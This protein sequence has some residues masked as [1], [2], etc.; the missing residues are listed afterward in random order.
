MDRRVFPD[1]KYASVVYDR[2]SDLPEDGRQES[3]QPLSKPAVVAFLDLGTNSIRL[4]LV[5]VNPDLS[6]TVLTRQKEVVRLGE[7]EF[8]DQTLQP[9][10]MQRATQI[11]RQFADLARTRQAQEI[12]AIATSATRE[13]ANQAEFVQLIKDE[14]GLELHVVSGKEEARLIYLGVSSGLN[15]GRRKALF[16]DIGGG[17]T[18]TIVGDQ[19][20]YDF[21]ETHKLGAMRLASLFVLPGETGP[22][23]K[24]RY[25]LLKNYVRNAIVRTVQHLKDHPVEMVLGSSGSITNLAEVAYRYFHD[26][27]FDRDSTVTLEEISDTLQMLCRL[28]LDERREVPGINP[29]RADIIIPGG[30]ILETFL[31]ELGLDTLRTSERGLL[32]G[33]L[34]DYLARHR[35]SIEQKEVTIRERSVLQLGRA[36]NFEEKHARTVARLALELFDSAGEAGMHELEDIDRELLYYA[37]LLHD[38]GAF[39]SY[40]NHHAHTYYLVHNA[41][42]LGF[43][44]SEVE[45][46]ATT[47]LFH[48]RSGPSKKH[49]EFAALSKNDQDRVRTLSMLLRLAESLDRSH[50]GI[51]Q[52]A[53]LEDDDRKTTCLE[54]TANQDCTLEVW[55][56]NTH[57][58]SF[59][60]VFGKRL[61]IKQITKRRQDTP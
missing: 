20:H 40:P 52:H 16:I 11:C 46:I 24:V 41:D 3:G 14:A 2:Q 53:R 54:I 25:E 51:I 61:E 57:L 12:I 33:L 22:L 32:E 59:R 50:A 34:E 39:I 15:L 31:E 23:D 1:R 19:H 28:P 7:G 30:V 37:A 27:D 58:D 47:A 9:E 35:T 4:L 60:K 38:T 18:E 55:G 29:F 48:R 6:Y 10:A 43:D 8:I 5:R 21:L 13:A 44:E 17:S 45:L 49:K 42:L 26:R 56:L 36:V